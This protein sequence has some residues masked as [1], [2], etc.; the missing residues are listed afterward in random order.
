[1]LMRI[2]AIVGGTNAESNADTLCEAFLKGCIAQGA[3]TEK[4]RLRELH[5]DHFTLD[6]YK[7]DKADEPDFRKI[8]EAILTCDGFVVASPVW[9]FSVPG[10][11]KNLIDRMGAFGLDASTRAKGMLGGK[12]FFLLYTGGSPA[13][14]WKGLMRRTTSA[15]PIALKYFGAAYCG[16]HYE[17]R[18]MKG[19]GIFRLVVNARSD[20]LTT[21]EMRGRA[22]G[23]IVKEFAAT[24]QLP[25]KQRFMTKL[26][27]FGQKIVRMIS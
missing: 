4:I 24:G 27:A 15:V 10:H 5:I 6:H 26:Y 7:P 23:K 16:T 20:S 17:G 2:V 21:A 9:N 13:P 14:A 19:K 18:C 1:M 12:P 22:F 8:R 25:F 3:T 11:L